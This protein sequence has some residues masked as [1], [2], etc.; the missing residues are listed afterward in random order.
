MHEGL[1][2]KYCL[3]M[4]EHCFGLACQYSWCNADSL[5]ILCSLAYWHFEIIPLYYTNNKIRQ[6][7]I[8][9]LAI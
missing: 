7:L 2:K 6:C 8:L 9:A 5:Y 1:L 4:C 3:I